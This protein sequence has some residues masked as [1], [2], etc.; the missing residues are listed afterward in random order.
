MTL[1]GVSSAGGVVPVGIYYQLDVH[2]ELFRRV[3]ET[4]LILAD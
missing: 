1:P 3:L 4:V 2:A